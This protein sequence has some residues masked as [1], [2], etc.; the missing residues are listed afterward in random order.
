MGSTPSDS[1][2]AASAAA[3]SRRLLVLRAVE[4]ADPRGDWLPLSARASAGKAGLAA[5]DGKFL[6]A[7][8]AALLRGIPSG[9]LKTALLAPPPAEPRW[10]TWWPWALPAGGLLLGLVSHELGADRRLNLLA[11]PLLGL[12]LWNVAVCVAAL[13]AEFRSRPA[14]VSPLPRGAA[15]IIDAAAGEAPLAAGAQAQAAEEWRKLHTPAMAAKGRLVF[16]ASAILL[17]LGM[18]GGMYLKG[19]GHAYRAAWES[20]FLERP[21]VSKLLRVAL[22]PASIVTGIPVPEVPEENNTAPAAPWIHLWAASAGLFILIPRLLLVKS[23]SAALRKSAPDWKTEFAAWEVSARATSTGQPLVACVVPVQCEP[24]SP[25]RDSLR[26]VLQ[27]LWGGQVIVDF[28]PSVGYGEE[29]EFVE[30][31]TEIPSHLVVMFPFSATPE[32]EIHGH[33]VKSLTERLAA[34]PHPVRA[35]VV[36]E[37]SAFDSRMKDLPEFDRRTA[38]RRGAWDRILGGALP[39][40]HLNDAAR[41]QPDRAA[42]ESLAAREPVRPWTPS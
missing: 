30:T 41:R 4:E 13:I 29:D 8:A 12:I 2:E 10:R 20:T 42:A 36:L 31:F 14:A 37:S 3:M 16:H 35:L 40:L 23:A 17:A 38:E 28:Q 15:G 11:F 6:T 19:L 34:A 32:A 18:V 21:A 24:D 39:V 1:P 33:L 7:R 22:G 25:L 5:P 9:P 26:A 27:H